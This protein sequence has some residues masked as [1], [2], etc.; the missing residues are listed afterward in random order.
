MPPP[1][2]FADRTR[3]PVAP[4]IASAYSDGRM[5]RALLP[6]GSST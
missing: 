1:R 5:P 6:E 3:V 4:L 2:R